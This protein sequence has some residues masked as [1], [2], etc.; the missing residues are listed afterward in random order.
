MLRDS[1]IV[2]EGLM[3]PQFSTK[4]GFGS[5]GEGWDFGSLRL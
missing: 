5:F 4:A 2:A 1:L 3:F